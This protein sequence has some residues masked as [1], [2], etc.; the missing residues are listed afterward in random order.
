MDFNFG[1]CVFKNE[2]ECV[3]WIG[4]KFDDNDELNIFFRT[5]V[6][7]RI[8]DREGSVEFKEVISALVLTGL[9]K[10]NI[11]NFLKQS[12]SVNQSWEISEA[13]AEAYLELEYKAIFPWNNKRDKK[14]SNAS[15]TG[16]DMV[17]FFKKKN[18]YQFLFGEIKSSTEKSSPPQVMSNKK[19]HMG[20]QLKSLLNNNDKII[21]LAKWLLFR[22]NKTMY[23]EQYKSALKLFIESDYKDFAL[24]GVLVRDTEV[25]E[26]DMLPLGEDLRNKLKPP[27]ECKLITIYLPWEL[28]YLPSK[29]LSGGA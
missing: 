16:T 25:N 13:L 21:N 12:E 29:I 18:K 10:E 11:E 1:H 14:N 9:K 28:S 6:A 8:K 2:G 27:T 3:T 24:V 7:D 19:E 17:G 5:K 15:L 4:K 20:G 26:N 23:F 22:V